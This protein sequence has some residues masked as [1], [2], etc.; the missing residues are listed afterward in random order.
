LNNSDIMIKNILKACD[1][2]KAYGFNVI[3]ISHISSIADYFII[4]SVNNERQAEA[5]ADEIDKQLSLLGIKIAH[6]EGFESKKWILLDYSD[7]IVHIFQ[8]EERN[9]YKLEQLW[10]DGKNVETEKYGIENWN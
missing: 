10:V 1:D 7:I 5:V 8:K 2:K 4:C 3:D 6:K 9:I